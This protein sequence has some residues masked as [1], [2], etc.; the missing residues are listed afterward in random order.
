MPRKRKAS[1]E[2]LKRE[3]YIMKE[4]TN[5]RIKCNIIRN[6]APP[7]DNDKWVEEMER[8]IEKPIFKQVMNLEG[9]DI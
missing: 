7:F 1:K 4:A 5:G 9:H 6:S 2:L 3:K 8:F